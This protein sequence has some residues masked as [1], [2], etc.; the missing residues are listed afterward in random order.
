MALLI[1][2]IAFQIGWFSVVI[3]AGRNAP[4]VG[5]LAIAA[6]ILLHLSRAK[7]PTAELTLILVCGAIG[8]VWDSI[9]VYVGWIAY[10]SGTFIANAAPYWIIAMWMLFATTLNVSLRWLKSS[11]ILAAL[12]G[13]VGGPMSYYTGAKLGGVVLVD[14]FAALTALGLGWALLMPVLLFLADRFNGITIRQSNRA[15]WILD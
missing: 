11:R 10:P 7:R 14:P 15:G 3:S 2:F 9:L 6:V 1:N 5:T 4:W 12:T 8:A 13:L